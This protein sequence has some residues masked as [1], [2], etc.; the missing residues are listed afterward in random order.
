MAAGRQAI[1]YF[2]SIDVNPPDGGYPKADVWKNERLLFNWMKTLGQL[3][4][5]EDA[6]YLISLNMGASA[7]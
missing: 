4:T 7:S 3:R 5:D 6:M 2:V 1:D